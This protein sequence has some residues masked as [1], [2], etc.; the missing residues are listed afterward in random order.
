MQLENDQFL[1]NL[2]Y[3]RKY[4]FFG[5]WSLATKTKFCLRF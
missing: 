2:F 5:K 4:L 1:E 3:Q